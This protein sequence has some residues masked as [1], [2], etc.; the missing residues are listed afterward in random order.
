MFFGW[1]ILILWMLVMTAS[2][3]CAGESLKKEVQSR[4]FISSLG[5]GYEALIYWRGEDGRLS[6][7]STSGYKNYQR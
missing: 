7:Y 4:A 2:L 5:P 1:R 3:A 6:C